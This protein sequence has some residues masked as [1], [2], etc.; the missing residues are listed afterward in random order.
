[1]DAVIFTID[2]YDDFYRDG[3]ALNPLAE[4]CANN[5]SWGKSGL[6]HFLVYCL[7]QENLLILLKYHIHKKD[8]FV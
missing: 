1:M 7:R 3:G 5:G 2:Y 4:V 8:I 6:N